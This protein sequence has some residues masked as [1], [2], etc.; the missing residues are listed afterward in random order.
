MLIILK[1]HADVLGLDYFF[2]LYLKNNTVFC[3]FV[4]IS[5]SYGSYWFDA[6]WKSGKVML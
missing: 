6:I 2:N 4:P 1:I 3:A 5:E